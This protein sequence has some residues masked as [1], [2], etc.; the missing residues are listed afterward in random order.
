MI[1]LQEKV[2]SSQAGRAVITGVMIFI[3]ASLVAANIPQTSYLQQKLNSIV[4]PV[5][6][7]VGLDQT[8]SVFAPEPRRETFALDASITYNDGTS[9]VWAVPTGDRAGTAARN[10][11]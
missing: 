7:S 1:D 6:D 2:E 3:L 9:E 8:W 4:Q 11:R 5:R 10:S